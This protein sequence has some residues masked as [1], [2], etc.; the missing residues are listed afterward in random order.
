M[1]GF[2]GSFEF[3][4]CHLFR[5]CGVCV[6]LCLFVFMCLL[7][8]CFYCVGGLFCCCFVLCL[9]RV[10]LLFVVW[11]LLFFVLL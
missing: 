4:V 6:R 9:F 1:F 2:V 7:S 11:C 8:V 10:L 3:V 5:V